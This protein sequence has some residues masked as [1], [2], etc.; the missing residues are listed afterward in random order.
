MHF[1]QLDFCGVSKECRPRAQLFGTHGPQSVV[2]F[3]LGGLGGVAL[4]EELCHWGCSLWVRTWG[5]LSVL[6]ESSCHPTL[7]AVSPACCYTLLPWWTLSPLHPDTEN[8]L[9]FLERLGYQLFWPWY[10]ITATEK[11]QPQ[12][13]SPVIVSPA[14]TDTLLWGTVGFQRTPQS[15]WEVFWGMRH[16]TRGWQ[17]RLLSPVANSQADSMD[18]RST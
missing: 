2:L 9:L 15:E 8:R 1:F 6:S 4:L 12:L 13:S 16:T 5:Q 14:L 10:F 17:D 18:I 11:Q 3:G 7:V